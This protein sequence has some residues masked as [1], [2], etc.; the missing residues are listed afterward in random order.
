MPAST[1]LIVDDEPIVCKTLIKL[2][3]HRGYQTTAV[4]TAKEALKEIEAAHVDVL[5]IDVNL[6]DMDGTVL[7]KQVK[8]RY[9]EKI[10]FLITG[11]PS[12]GSAVDALDM[13]AEGYFLKPFVPAVLISKVEAA[14]KQLDLERRLKASEAKL[15]ALVEFSD[16]HIFMLDRN[17]IY[18]TSNERGG[19]SGQAPGET[20]LG[21]SLSD[22]YSADVCDRYRPM[23]RAVFDSGK[24]AE[25]E[26]SLS[27]GEGERHLMD[28]LYPILRDGEVWA[29]GGISRDITDRKNME[30]ALI[31]S[32]VSLGEAQRIARLGAREWDIL[33][34]TV[35]WSDEAYR[36]FG[37]DFNGRK[38]SHSDSILLI[39]PDDQK[40]VR[41]Y[42]SRL[43]NGDNPGKVEY[44]IVRKDGGVRIIEEQG[45]VFTDAAGNPV[46]ILGTFRDVTEEK[47]LRQESEYRLQ[48]IIQADKMS[49][50]G[51]VVAGVAHEI[52][53][54]NSFITYNVPLLED[55]WRMFEPIIEQF[56]SANPGWRCGHMGIKALCR[57]MTEIIQAIKIGSD[58]IN[59]V[60]SNLK[61]F[62]RVDDSTVGKPVQV[63]QVIEKTMTIV[64][65][66]VRKAV[67]HLNI[68]LMPDLPLIPGHFQKLEQVVANLVLNAV[69]AIV[70]AD[71]GEISISTR[72]IER[73]Q[74]VIIEVADNGHGMAPEVVER[75][76]DPFFTTR[77]DSGGTGL[78]LS[79]TYSLIKEHNGIIGVLSRPGTGSRFTVHLP[80]DSAQKLDLQPTILCVDD[81][82]QILRVLHTFFVSVKNMSLNTLQNPEEVLGYLKNHPEVD[83]IIS[84]IRMPQISGWDLY[85]KIRKQFPLVRVVLYSGD[86]ASLANKPPHI[87]EPDHLLQKPFNFSELFGIIDKVGRQRL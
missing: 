16:G 34:D 2:F 23:V 85:M 53:N 79:V 39:H 68:D 27:D 61:D 10:C 47:K 12:I 1:L 37:Q 62:A 19:K 22:V 50:L 75:V 9:Q 20:I 29:V 51:E 55:T 24:T 8:Q 65:A 11:N 4:H 41:Q 31:R 80:L 38:Y 87:P 21:R 35:S 69:N 71:S 57:D 14:L 64:G 49:S 46:R 60:V 73:L 54:P 86:P 48:Q 58:R 15:R 78:G 25:F 70:H 82:P 6:P 17:G 52:N 28:L 5:L 83:I 7:L 84:D 77:R 76:F 74:A 3:N 42:E 81:D 44:R 40:G 63:N 72:F 33:S 26:Y 36:I 59:K 45:K 30:K 43:L 56:D 66:R 67:R 18:Q 13:G 32:N